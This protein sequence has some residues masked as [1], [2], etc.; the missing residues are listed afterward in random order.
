MLQNNKS[1]FYLKDKLREHL[2]EIAPIR[3]KKL[4]FFN[5]GNSACFAPNLG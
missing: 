5:Q 4:K 2:N 1:H 3:E